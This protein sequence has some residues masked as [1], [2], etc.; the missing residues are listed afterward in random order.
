M[1]TTLW[2]SAI[3]LAAACATLGASALAANDRAADIEALYQR[4]RAA[5]ESGQSGQ[6]RASCLQEAAA[7]RDAAKRGQ[8]DDAQADYERNALARC[9][10]LPADERDS[11][12]RRTRG[13]G[14]TRGSVSDGGIYREYREL[15]LPGSAPQ[16]P[17]KP[18]PEN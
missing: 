7:A 16:A 5:C 15:T 10:A 18:Q 8:L 3:A 14:E 4:E 12:V 6:D 2:T 11:C 1:R 9:E 17:G 13:E